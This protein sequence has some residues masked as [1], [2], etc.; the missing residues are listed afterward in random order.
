MT[1]LRGAVAHS[2]P[3]WRGAVPGN[4]CFTAALSDSQYRGTFAEVRLSPP[5]LLSALLSSA[6]VAWGYGDSEISDAGNLDAEKVSELDVKPPGSDASEPDAAPGTGPLA[7]RTQS[8]AEGAPVCCVEKVVAYP[9]TNPD[10]DFSCVSEGGQCALSYHCD[11]DG[12][13][14]ASTRCCGG[15]PQAPDGHFIYQCASATACALAPVSLGCTQPSDCTSLGQVCC[16][17]LS[18]S[19]VGV[20]GYY[21]SRTGCVLATLCTGPSERVF[22]LEDNDCPA[23]SPSCGDSTLLPGKRVCSDASMSGSL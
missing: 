7:C 23:T 1:E 4:A 10:S 20:N 19:L 16:G 2:L 6:C 3:P 5:L 21:Y 9:E 18:P 12:D 15:S 22:C 13:C 11:S 8:C 14:P 17:A